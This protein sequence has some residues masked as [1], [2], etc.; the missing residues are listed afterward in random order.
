VG[1]KAFAILTGRKA[2]VRFR[3]FRNDRPENQTPEI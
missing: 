3:V 1:K 2:M